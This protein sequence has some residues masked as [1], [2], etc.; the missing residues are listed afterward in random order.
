MR[1]VRA[2]VQVLGVQILLAAVGDEPGAETVV[3]RLADRSV[4]LAP[5]DLVVRRW[6]VDDELVLRGAA[7][8]LA[9]ADDEWTLSGDE[10]LTGPDGVLHELRR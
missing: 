4:D 10:T 5:P 2:D 3:V 9:G 7:G 8:V 6:L 1:W